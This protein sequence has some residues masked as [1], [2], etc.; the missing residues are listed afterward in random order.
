MDYKYHKNLTST[1]LHV[2]GYIQDSDPGEVGSGILWIDTSGGSTNWSVKIRNSTDTAWELVVGGGTNY[3]AG[4]HLTLGSGNIFSVD[5][6]FV[7]NTG[8]TMIGD[9]TL[10]DSVLQFSTGSGE[11]DVNLYRSDSGI[12]KTDDN[13]VIDK[14][15]SA[16]ADSAIDSEHIVHIEE[17]MSVS[18]ASA[19][20]LSV[21]IENTSGS[22]EGLRFNAESSGGG[23][24]SANGII[25]YATS[26]VEDGYSQGGLFFSYGK[27]VSGVT[28]YG[29]ITEVDPE[30][31][32]G[33][34]GIAYGGKFDVKSGSEQYG[35][36][37]TELD[38]TS[39][40]Y[41]VYFEGT[42]TDNSINWMGDTNLYRSSS[43][44]LKT[45]DNLVID[46][47]L[48]AGANSA[49]DSEHIVH[50]EEE[51]SVSPSSARGL[52]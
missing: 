9:L 21:H 51:M 22:V 49:I 47:H 40:S 19:R 35:I 24:G 27:G 45:D 7:L 31:N 13:L 4:D 1:D 14:H 17:E 12:L 37:I 38:G 39:E 25:G 15:L 42:G 6:D 2:P 48:S 26:S 52:S 20:G 36:Y 16:G 23:T 18:P 3:T 11:A 44:T 43:N 46:K 28:S 50:I 10:D 34:N 8:D 5:D 33:S 30:H 29:I 32:A 41:A